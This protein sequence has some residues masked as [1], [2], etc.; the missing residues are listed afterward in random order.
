MSAAD[1]I[2]VHAHF[3]TEQSGRGDWRDVN[4]ARLEAGRQMGITAHVAS[5]L[6]TWGANSP[7]Y[8]PSPE[9][10]TH[11][12]DAMLELARANRGLVFGYC[13]VNP[14]YPEHA[15]E[16]MARCLDAGMIGVKLAASRRADDALLDPIVWRAAERG[17]PVLHHVW[18]HRRREW[19][20]QEASDAV[21]LARLA[22]RHP[23]AN[24]ILAHLG[25]GGDWAH[26]LRAVR[27]VRNVWID[28][29][30]SG[31]DSGMLEAALDAV[32]PERL[33]WGCDVTMGTGLA[34]LRYLETLGL[35]PGVLDLI[36]WRNAMGLFPAG[37]F[38]R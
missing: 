1:L 13:V 12:N 31:V 11:G 5:V 35:E 23:R 15:A 17:V 38:D 7:T 25:G 22:Q 8:F 10:A 9:D 24:L 4:A 37:V 19:P 34:K 20:G 28:L 3:F 18:Q 36:K 16:E 21:E 26:S 32:G 33:V 6:G 2:D 27:D 29:S 30:G 14:N